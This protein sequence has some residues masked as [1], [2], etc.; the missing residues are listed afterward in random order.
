MA[1]AAIAFTSCGNNDPKDPNEGNNQQNDTIPQ[2]KAAD[3]TIAIGVDPDWLKIA[4]FCIYDSVGTA[5]AKSEELVDLYTTWDLGMSYAEFHT[6]NFDSCTWVF[7]GYTMTKK[8]EPNETIS[9]RC[10]LKLKEN[11]ID[12]LKAME[13]G[14]NIKLPVIRACAT[15]VNAPQYHCIGTTNSANLDVD[16][17][18]KVLEGRDPELLENLAKQYSE[19]LSGTYAYDGFSA[20]Q[21]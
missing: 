4:D 3:V 15:Q 8:F 19:F 18:L 9:F 20:G 17:A 14:S 6:Q 7:K 5:A 16:A 21:L 10:E 11:Y 2:A 13:P 1:V 12:I